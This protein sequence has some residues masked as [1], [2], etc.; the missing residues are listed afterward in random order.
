MSR[1]EYQAN[2]DLQGIAQPAAVEVCELCGG[3]DLEAPH[4]GD[5]LRGGYDAHCWDCDRPTFKALEV[6][7]V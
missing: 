4:K 5:E 6:G 1:S 7:N 3:T 2:I